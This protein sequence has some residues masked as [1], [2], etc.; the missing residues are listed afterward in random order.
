MPTLAAR[1]VAPGIFPLDEVL[2]LGPSQFSPRLVEWAVLFGTLLPFRVAARLLRLV[3]GVTISA[4]TVRRLTERAGAAGVALDTDD[5]ERIER[6]LPDPAAGPAVQQLSVDGAM[7]SLVD[8]SWAEVKTLAI[9]T[10]TAGQDRGGAPVTVDLSYFS[11]LADAERFG[12][13]ATVETQR[14][15][16]T[17]AGVVVGVVDGAAWCQGFLDLH[18]HDAV[19]ILDFPHAVGYLAAAAEARYPHDVLRAQTWLAEQRRILLTGDPAAVLAA[20]AQGYPDQ[21]SEQ[22]T[23]IGEALRYLTSRRDQIHYAAFR[24]RGYPIGSGCVESA[25]KLIVEARLK[26]RGMH[27]SRAQV[28]PLV[29]L[30]CL[31]GNGRWQEQWP[32]LWGRIRADARA[33]TTR[34]RCIRQQRDISPILPLPARPM[35]P[36]PPEP[37]AERPL[38]PK[39]VV[40]GKPTKDHPWRNHDL[41][42]RRS[43]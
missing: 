25:N 18:R 27:W 10:V 13:L 29:C 33:S 22:D 34:R 37:L 28:N 14:R 19:R 4:E 15:G 31:D 23:P 8:G 32:R 5:L 12:R 26:G 42:G 17:T 16:T 7:V 11:R 40:N 39:L 21:P 24:S 36:V 6:E 35:P 38:R 9:G 43:A 20:L 41:V 30:R 2:A 3:S 1:A